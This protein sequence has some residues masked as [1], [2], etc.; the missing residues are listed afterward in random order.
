MCRSEE[1]L[2]GSVDGWT[3]SGTN[4]N[5]EVRNNR[6]T[7]DSTA[8]VPGGTTGSEHRYEQ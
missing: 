4:F 1:I 5:A 3:I 2:D 8:L 7:L 6:I